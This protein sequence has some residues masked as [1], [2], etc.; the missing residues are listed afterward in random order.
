MGRKDFRNTGI[1][2]DVVRP[3]L[4]RHASDTRWNAF[5]AV[6]EERCREG[7]YDWF[8]DDEIASRLR[9]NSGFDDVGAQP[10]QWHIFGRSVANAVQ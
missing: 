7:I 3:K 1:N 5:N 9:W 4:G 8:G 2:I 6:R 10:D